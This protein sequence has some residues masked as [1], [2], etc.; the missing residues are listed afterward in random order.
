[1][2]PPEARESTVSQAKERDSA[3]L[4]SESRERS[5]FVKSEDKDTVLLRV[6]KKSQGLTNSFVNVKDSQLTV[7]KQLNMSLMESTVLL[8]K[9][10]HFIKDYAGKIEYINEEL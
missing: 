10:Q 4:Q 8:D 6:S 1:M 5:T 3:L 7:E 2:S 9:H